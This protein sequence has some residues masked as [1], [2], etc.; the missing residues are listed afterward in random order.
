MQAG[1]GGMGSHKHGI[2]GYSGPSPR[3]KFMRAFDEN[4]WRDKWKR[5]VVKLNNKSV[6][7]L[8]ESFRPK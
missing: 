3:T 7:D 1:R 4:R 2:S 5:R 8:I 6:R